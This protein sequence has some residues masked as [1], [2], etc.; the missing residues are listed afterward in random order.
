MKKQHVILTESDKR[1]LEQILSKGKLSVKVFRRATGLLMLHNG[2]TLEAA[3]SVM[4]V[5]NDT[6]RTCRNRYR[7]GGLDKALYDEGRSG[8]PAQISGKAQ[9]KLTALACSQP[10]DGR[11]RWTLRL[12]ADR[13]V[14]LGY[15]DHLSHTKANDILKKTVSDRILNKP[16][17]WP[18]RMPSSLPKW[19]T[20]SVSMKSP[21]IRSVR[22]SA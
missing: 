12:L 18:R 2:S 13:A 9:A 10:P 21:T 20:F 1:T 15:C 8:R 11:S 7:Q 6:V 16:G 22:S 19:K 5:E 17:A 3:A 14:E 4:H